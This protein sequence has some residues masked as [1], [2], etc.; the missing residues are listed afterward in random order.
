LHSSI[1][2]EQE[3]HHMESFWP[4]NIYFAVKQSHKEVSWIQVPSKLT[5][6]K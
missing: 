5:Q 4:V 3:T 2:V 1:L 6:T